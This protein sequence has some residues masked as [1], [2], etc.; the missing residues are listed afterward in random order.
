ISVRAG[1]AI[2]ADPESAITVKVT[3]A[4]WW[5]KFEYEDA[6]ASR[7]V[8]T[9]NELHIPTG[10]PVLLK[11]SSKDVIHSFWVPNLAGKRDL[12]PAKSDVTLVIQADKAGIYRGQCAEFCGHQHAQMGLRIVAEEPGKFESWLE[13]QREPA[14]QPEA[15]S[16]LRGQDVFLR[17][18]CVMCH[19]VRGTAAAAQVAPDLT[20]I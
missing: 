3:G 18:K 4:Q 15:E 19:T 14:R 10:T 8:T 16:A 11:L 13:H 5:W 20:H 17:A 12:F 9:S 6:V 1:N 2:V 7:M